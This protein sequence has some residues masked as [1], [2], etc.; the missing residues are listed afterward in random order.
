MFPKRVYLVVG[1]VVEIVV[2]LRD[3]VVAFLKFALPLL[4]SSIEGGFLRSAL[5]DV[6]GVFGVALYVVVCHSTARKVGV[7]DKYLV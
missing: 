7:I 2:G 5:V 6:G 4:V 1:L 3:T